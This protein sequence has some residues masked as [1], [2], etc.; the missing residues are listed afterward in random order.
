MSEVLELRDLH[1][2][3]SRRL[4]WEKLLGES[5]WRHF[6]MQWDFFRLSCRWAAAQWQPL[7][8]EARW[9]DRVLGMLPL[10]AHRKYERWVS[11]NLVTGIGPA[12]MLGREVTAAWMQIANHIKRRSLKQGTLDLGPFDPRVGVGARLE[13]AFS[14]IASRKLAKLSISQIEFDTT[15]RSWALDRPGSPKIELISSQSE[16]RYEQGLPQVEWNALLQQL[17]QPQVARISGVTAIAQHANVAVDAIESL[18]EAGLIWIT[19]LRGA[20]STGRSIVW[21]GDREHLSPLVELRP[22]GVG[23]VDGDEAHAVLA[24]FH[25]E[26]VKRVGTHGIAWPKME[27]SLPVNYRTYGFANRLDVRNAWHVL[28]NP[29]PIATPVLR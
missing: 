23:E 25:A 8:L 26:S 28:W 29:L 27:N 22:K 1:E 5:R 17:E 16:S 9:D 13:T 19:R 2:I 4:V 14:N 21:V 10:L 18:A 7:V 24:A 6:S 15:L 11:P 20:R 12:M 3:E